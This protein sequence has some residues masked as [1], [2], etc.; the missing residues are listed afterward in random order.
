M[1][2]K[3]ENYIKNIIAPNCNNEEKIIEAFIKFDRIKF[4][5]EAFALKAYNDDAL[6]I[7]FG[8]TI[9]KPSTVAYMT[10]IL[11][12]KPED[13]I[14]EIGTGSGFQAA[15]L[16]HLCDTVYTVERIKQL[17]IRT[18][19]LLRNLFIHNIKFKLDDGSIG[20]QE[21]APFDKIIV[22]AATDILPETLLKQLKINGKMI[23]P[24]ADSISLITKSKTG[25]KEKKLKD[26]NFVKL[27]L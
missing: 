1:N 14:L 13:K 23:I 24:L 17:Y 25:L 19:D 2:K 21:K 22:T 9:S 11:D 6:P 7:G 10:Y 16:S 18:C 4:I 15:I 12:I 26:C 27:I 20:W 5:D 8:Q 3:F